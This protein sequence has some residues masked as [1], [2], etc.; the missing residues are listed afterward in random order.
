MSLV[1]CFAPFVLAFL[2]NLLMDDLSVY[3]EQRYF[4]ILLLYTILTYINIYYARKSGI[5]EAKITSYVEK[6]LQLNVMQ[7]V[8][9]EKEKECDDIGV[10]TDILENDFNVLESMLLIQVEFFCNIV[11]FLGLF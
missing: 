10:M 2:V 5:V 1:W 6:I 4:I 8:L 3:N 9:E 7:R 11:S